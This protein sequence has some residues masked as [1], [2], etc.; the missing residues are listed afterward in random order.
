MRQSIMMDTCYISDGDRND[1]YEMG[2]QTDQTGVIPDT[3]AD[4]Q[5]TLAQLH[6]LHGCQL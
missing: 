4:I 5:Q 6:N 3:Y 2:Y 1:R